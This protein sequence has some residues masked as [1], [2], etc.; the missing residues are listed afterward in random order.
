MSIRPL[1]LLDLPYLYSFREEA[2]GLDTARRLTRGNP[3]GAVG[4]LSYVNPS[5]HIYGAIANGNKESVVG[6]I[7]HLPDET[8]AKMLY[9]APASQLG[10]PDLPGLIDYLSAQAGNWGAFHVIAEVDESSEAFVSLRK[11]GFSV[12]AWQRMWDASDI[13]EVSQEFDWMKVKSVHLP[14]VQSLY[15]Q[16]VP[17]LM[18]PMEP[19]PKSANGWMC[20]EGVKCYVSLTQGVYGMVLSPLIHPETSNVSEKL[21][22][23]ITNLPD[24]RNRPVYVCVRSYQAW[25][26]PVLADLGAKGAD[27]QAVMVKHLAHLVKEEQTVRSAQPAAVRVQPSQANRIEKEK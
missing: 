8:F 9:L 4:L 7:I 11:S 15:H 24:R 14:S 22:S 13:V 17:P 1:A 26:E 10:H 19:Q 3:L 12:Y 20:N 18:H 25:L 27:R 21:A 23:I 6:G 5:R 16:I 2:V